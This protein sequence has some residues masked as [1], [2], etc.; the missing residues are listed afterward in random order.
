MLWLWHRLAATAPIGTLVWEPP[1]AEGAALEKT[2]RSKRKKKETDS[3]SCLEVSC[4]R[5]N[6]YRW[7]MGT[8]G[9]GGLGVS[10]AVL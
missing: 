8:S 6:H 9:E 1:Y 3:Q 2:K 5:R 7:F 10:M 4:S